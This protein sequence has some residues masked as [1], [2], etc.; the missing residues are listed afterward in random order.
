M[1]LEDQGLILPE[2]FFSPT[3]NDGK[4]HN[5]PSKNSS[6]SGHSDRS[7]VN[8]SCAAWG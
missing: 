2:W 8:F 7:K 3:V 4:N 1:E 6:V 5:L